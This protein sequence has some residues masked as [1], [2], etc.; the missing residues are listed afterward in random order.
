MANYPFDRGQNYCVECQECHTDCIITSGINKGKFPVSCKYKRDSGNVVSVLEPPTPGCLRKQDRL[1]VGKR[2]QAYDRYRSVISRY[3]ITFVYGAINEYLVNNPEEETTLFSESYMS[4]DSEENILGNF[5]AE[6]K[7]EYLLGRFG[8]DYDL[9][10]SIVAESLA[11][12]S[13]DKQIQL[14]IFLRKNYLLQILELLRN[15][16]SLSEEQSKINRKRAAEI[17]RMMFE[18]VCMERGLNSPTFAGSKN[19][20]LL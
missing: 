6:L 10:G 17:Y 12:E 3:L 11:A 8:A 5:V 16:P 7:E 18:R 4:I 19:L 1:P 2:E 13:S 20:S 14:A 9:F 15:N